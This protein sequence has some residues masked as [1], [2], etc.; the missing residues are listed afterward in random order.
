MTKPATY[1]CDTCRKRYP[2]GKETTVYLYLNQP[3]FNHLDTVCP[4]CENTYQVWGVTDDTGRYM[5]DHNMSDA[6][7]LNWIIVDFA[8]ESIWRAFCQAT[9]REFPAE[10]YI[11][12]REQ[13]HIDHQAQMFAWLL[14]HGE[15]IS[16]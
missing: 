6:D 12:P 11:G 10:R 2:M 8:E 5:M 3:W 15:S 9:N 1:G 7:P 16:A 4:G 13:A 14:D